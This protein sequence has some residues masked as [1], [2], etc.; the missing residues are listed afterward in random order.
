[1]EPLGVQMQ[2]IPIENFNTSSVNFTEFCTSFA[3]ERFAG[4]S[5]DA[6]RLEYI[7]DRKLITHIFSFEDA[8]KPYGYVLAVV[9]DQS[10]HYWFSF[11]DT[12]YMRSH[13]LGKWM[14]W[15]VIEWSQAQSLKYT[16][17]GTC[18]REKSLYKVRDHKGTEFFD[19]T[20]WN[21]D[22][23]FLKALCKADEE[24]KE[25]DLLKLEWRDA[26]DGKAF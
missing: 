24:L 17:I 9:T 15:R 23:D 25:K 2:V 16:Y 22:T 10:L 6:S 7:L 20:G 21:S 12:D 5:M 19:G 4:G 11:Y 26:F 18:Y 13:S 14:M 8:Q 3:E 1:M